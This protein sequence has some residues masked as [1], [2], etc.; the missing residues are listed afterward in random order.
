MSDL[1][2]FSASRDEQ[3]GSLMRDAL[4]PRDDVAFVAQVRAR[5]SAHQPGWDDELAGWFWQG[6]IAASLAIAAAG[7]AWTSGAT[8]AQA[9]ASVAIELLDGTRPGADVLLAS[10][11]A[12]R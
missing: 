10:I 7:W 3:L 12:D 1:S 2:P 11:T 4:A 5:I 9:E 6:L 8:T